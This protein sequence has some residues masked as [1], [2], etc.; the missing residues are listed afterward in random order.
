MTDDPPG[1]SY[2]K[3]ANGI[4]MT[5]MPAFDKSMN[6]TQM[7]QISLLIANADKLPDSVKSG[8]KASRIP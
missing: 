5:G 6:T 7:W 8:L 2:W 3:I 4:R 1:E